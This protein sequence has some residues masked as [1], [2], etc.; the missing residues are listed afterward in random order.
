MQA[1]I[2]TTPRADG[3]AKSDI[4]PAN[5]VIDNLAMMTASLVFDEERL[6][7]MTKNST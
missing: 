2:S 3:C 6:P 4:D 5:V 7:T 1:R